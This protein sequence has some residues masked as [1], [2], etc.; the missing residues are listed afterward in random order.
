MSENALIIMAKNPILGKVKTRLAK[1]L[2]DD[3]TLLLYK[4]LMSITRKITDKLPCDKFI[5]YSDFIDLTDQWKNSEY[6]K[7]LQSNSVNLGDKMKN[8]FSEVFKKGY[9]RC[10][11]IGT[12]CPYITPNIL[13]KSLHKLSDNDAVIG[14][15]TDG[16]FYLL[17]VKNTTSLTFENITWSTHT[18][19]SKFIQNLKKEHLKFELLEKL[20]DIDDINSYSRS[21]N[22]IKLHELQ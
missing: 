7:C 10:A 12:D 11:I 2:G 15:A 22:S 4:K 5:F 19:L 1:D 21:L 9:K 8:A 3:A 18:V 13:I 20:E 17:S 16:G 14:P 6:H